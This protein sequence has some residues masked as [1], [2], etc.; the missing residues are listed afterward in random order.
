MKTASADADP[1]MGTEQD[2]AFWLYSSGSNGRPKATPHLQKSLLVTADSYARNV[3]N[4]SEQDVCFSLC[5]LFVAYGLGNSLTFPLRFGASTVL[6]SEHAS[7]EK[8]FETLEKY[9]PSVFFAVPTQY[10]SMLKKMNDR[11]V[12]RFRV[13]ASAGESLPL[14]VCR[15]WKA[16]TGLDIIDGIGATEALHIFISNQPGDVREGS[17]GRLVPG[18]EARIVDEDDVDV[19]EGESGHLLIRGKSLTPGYWNRP[20]ENMAKM[21]EGGW[22]RTGD[23]YSQQDGYFTYEGRGDDM[24]K[25]GGLWVSPMEIEYAL[26]EHEAV[27]ECAVV[28]HDVE[29]LT[30]PFAHV[31][32]NEAARPRA[33]EHLE[34]ELLDFV[35]GQLP[36]FKRL[37]G[38][39]FTDGLPKT[40]TG[41]IQRFKLRQKK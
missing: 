36:K 14:D 20:D 12:P 21:V 24:I 1:R 13:C 33:K 10:N 2:I 15:Q 17:S 25:V 11:V 22:F 18:Y 26:T 31:V 8:V 41:K 34:R 38:I 27:Y 9:K 3:L 19:P 4:I 30:K 29:G 40:A 32:L 5:K 28:G 23:L 16:N 7:P 6:L 35:A 39:R 37:W